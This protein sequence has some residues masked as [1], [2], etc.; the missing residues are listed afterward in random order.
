MEPV[1]RQS[2]AATS[3]DPG[4]VEAKWRARWAERATNVADI[5]DA[6][7]PYYALMMFP[8][9]SAEG[10]HVGNMFAFTGNDILA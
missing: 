6:A 9:P 7:R 3:Y 8:Y 5:R 1:D 10:L 2:E 4:A